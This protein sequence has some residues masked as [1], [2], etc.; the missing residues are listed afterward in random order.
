[1][2][3]DARGTIETVLNNMI[4]IKVPFLADKSDI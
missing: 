1:M 3:D 4:L 2:H